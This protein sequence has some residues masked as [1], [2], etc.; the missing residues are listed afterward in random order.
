MTVNKKWSGEPKVQGQK[1]KIR[2]EGRV[3]FL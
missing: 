1:K 3:V 2:G